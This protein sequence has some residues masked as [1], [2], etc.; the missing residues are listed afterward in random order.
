M[1]RQEQ[2]DKVCRILD[3]VLA[4]RPTER[5]SL[6][7]ATRKAFK[8][9]E[10][11]EWVS[12]SEKMPGKEDC[13]MDCL[14]TRKGE[15]IGNYT[16]MAVAESDGTWTHEDWR[17]IALGENVYEKKTG[18]LKTRGDEIIA[19][20]PLPEPWKGEQHEFDK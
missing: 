5:D 15:Y 1:I 14:V 13:P 16:D 11:A 10:G 7:V 19:W 17:A 18:L 4:N 20:K 6:I 9:L 3:N 8:A 12:V 2:C